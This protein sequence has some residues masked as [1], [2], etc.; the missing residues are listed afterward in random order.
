MDY[1]L[2]S[3][4]QGWAVCLLLISYDIACQWF[5]NFFKRM[6]QQWPPELRLHPQIQQI[7]PAIP[8]FHLRAHG[9]KD[10]AQYCLHWLRGIGNCNCEG[11]E[12]IWSGSNGSANSTKSMGPGTRHDTLDCVFNFW[13]WRKYADM[14]K[15]P[16]P[17]PSS[18]H[19]KV[20]QG[21]LCSRSTN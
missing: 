14:G 2:A 17:C 21:D 6:T 7:R 10:H 5:V 8:A 12:R 1:I 19:P 16:L 13:N 11:P 18:S 9:Q 4:L 3:A 20:S 15:L